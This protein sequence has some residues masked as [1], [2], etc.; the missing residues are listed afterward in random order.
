VGPDQKPRY[1]MPEPGSRSLA[2][3]PAEPFDD[4]VGARR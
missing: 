4:Y 2:R 3:A 1:W